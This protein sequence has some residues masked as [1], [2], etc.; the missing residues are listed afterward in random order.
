MDR[1]MARKSLSRDS[2]SRS[3]A[4]FTVSLVVSGPGVKSSFLSVM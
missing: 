1:T 3:M 2:A 4:A